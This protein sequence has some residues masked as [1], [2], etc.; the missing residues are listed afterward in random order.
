MKMGYTASDL[1]ALD[2]DKALALLLVSHE[3]EKAK[4][5]LAEREAKKQSKGKK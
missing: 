5:E 1:R 4:H 2:C 3:M